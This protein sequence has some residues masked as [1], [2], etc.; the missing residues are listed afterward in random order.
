MFINKKKCLDIQHP[1]KDKEGS[2][3]HIKEENRGKFN[4]T[5][6]QTGESTEELTHSKNPLTRKRAIF[7]QNAAKWKHANGGIIQK[8]QE[9]GVVLP[10]ALAG[11]NYANA[12]TYWE[13]LGD[14]DPRQ[15]AGIMGNMYA[16]S[17]MD[18]NAQNAN[19]IGLT[20]M[21]KK[22]LYPWVSQTY[23]KGADG[24]LA[25]IKD[26]VSGKLN[27]SKYRGS[28]GYNSAKYIAA[29]K[30]AYTPADS[31]RFFQQYYER[32]GMR[33]AKAR[34]AAAEAIYKLFNKQSE[35]EPQ[36]TISPILSKQ[37]SPIVEMPDAT[38]VASPA[39]FIKLA[40]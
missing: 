22:Q 1:F 9:A 8:M 16:E 24:E 14:I 39:P 6:E 29:H 15:K 3:I 34:Q 4:K 38:L 37:I 21:S 20:Q 13:A 26:Y 12:K 10:P 5:K 11:M 28:Y 17:K 33:G 23:G 35:P 27:N 2:K 32:N 30:G 36:P 31:A 7:A 19:Y 40:K 25:Y 18:P